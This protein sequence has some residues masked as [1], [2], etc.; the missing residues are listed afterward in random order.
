MMQGNVNC[1]P[2]LQIPTG[3][4]GQVTPQYF[5]NLQQQQ[6]QQQQA[7]NLLNQPLSPPYSATP[8]PSPSYPYNAPNKDG[9]RNSEQL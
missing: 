2:L 9:E 8:M 6:Q 3:L 5:Q 1:F 7:I 4:P